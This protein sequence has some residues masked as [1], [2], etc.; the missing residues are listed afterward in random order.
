MVKM[1]S[2]IKKK[3]NEFVKAANKVGYYKLLNCS[4]GNMSQRLDEKKM[5]MSK[6]GSWLEELNENEVSI[7]EIE[8]G[9]VLNDIKPTVENVFH[10]GILNNREDVNT[11]LHFQSPY[12]TIIA[13]SCK[14]YFNFNVIAEVPIYIGSIDT[15]P[16]L[17]PGSIELAEAVINSAKTNN[18]I[19]M[20]NHG[21]VA[22]GKD[23]ND[24]IQKAKFFELACE[25]MIKSN[26]QVNYLTEADVENLNKY[27]LKKT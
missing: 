8:S 25:I 17:V 1:E 24:V 11:V 23:Y 18:L 21:L 12:A 13:C 20:K 22:V 9:K 16:Y 19:I 15:V 27:I 3:I 2:D 4:S 7:C 10:R 14:S 6:S 26:G 5:L